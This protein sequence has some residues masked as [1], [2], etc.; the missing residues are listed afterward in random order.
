MRLI[1]KKT[2]IL[3]LPAVRPFGVQYTPFSW[4]LIRSL[5]YYIGFRTGKNT[6]CCKLPAAC[7]ISTPATGVLQSGQS[8][9]RIAY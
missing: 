2:L 5:P 1:F 9:L 8:P 4:Q 6:A 7:Y 3:N